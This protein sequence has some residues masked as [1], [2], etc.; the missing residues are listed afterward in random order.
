MEVIEEF[1]FSLSFGYI[2]ELPFKAIESGC[3][4]ASF[5]PLQVNPKNF[6]LLPRRQTV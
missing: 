2:P 5:T 6:G 1:H 4:I 3:D